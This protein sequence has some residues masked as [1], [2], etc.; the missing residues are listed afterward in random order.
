MRY[1]TLAAILV[2][3]FGIISCS[4]ETD[5]GITGRYIGTQ[6]FGIAQ[7]GSAIALQLSERGATLTG[8]VTPPFQGDV[9][10]I[11]MGEI[12]GG[13]FRFNASYGGFTYHYEGTI[14]GTKLTGSFEPL[15]CVNPGSGET[16]P[17]DSNG[18]FTATK[19]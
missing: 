14:Q 8:T 9:A 2:L 19:Q 18:T 11:S 17:T 13:Q 10:A 12:T 6:N 3:A 15:G 5:E 7:A 1:A 16:C 4:K